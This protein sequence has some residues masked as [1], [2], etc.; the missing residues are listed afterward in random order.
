M[1][2]EQKLSELYQFL[3]AKK[4]IF[5]REILDNY[6]STLESYP[7]DWIEGLATLDEQALFEFDSRQNISSSLPQEFISWW[8]EIETLTTFPKVETSR[9][10]FD[11]WTWHK[12][13]EKKRHEL[14][15]IAS[16]I[17]KDKNYK[18]LDLCAGVGHLSRVLSGHYNFQSTVVDFDHDLL[19]KGKSRLQKYPLP[20]APQV[21]FVQRDIR[22]EGI[23]DLASQSDF[24]L[25]LHN[26]GDLSVIHLQAIKDLENHSFLNIGCCYYKMP[27]EGHTNL[28]IKAKELNLPWTSI[29]LY[30]ATRAHYQKDIKD[31]RNKIQVKM[32]R[33]ALHLLLDELKHPIQ[34]VGEIPVRFYWGAFSDYALLK[35][36]E[37]Q[38]QHSWTSEELEAFYRD[39]NIQKQIKQMILANLIRWQ[40]GR[41]L[42]SYLILDRALFLEDH[43]HACD[44][45]ALFDEQISPR[46]LAIISQNVTPR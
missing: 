38:I 44:V 45:V 13:T 18:F 7:H 33:Y 20:H 11:D 25:A 1:N 42:E 24:S 32:F 19:E 17:P 4:G 27:V 41:V 2:K 5:T 43:G 12:V 36:S 8:E 35:L 28:S 6:P 3:I 26:C 39:Q 22:R 29:A 21:Q 14:S 10:I 34:S 16:I 31:F 46:N 15:Q 37:H 30:L 9:P 23:V 40:L